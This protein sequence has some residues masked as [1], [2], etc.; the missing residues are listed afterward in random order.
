M[1]KIKLSG[2]IFL[3]VVVI[4]A[5]ET[6]DTQLHMEG[7]TGSSAAVVP[8]LVQEEKPTQ[9][10]RIKAGD[11][12][13]LT[14][15]SD[16]ELSNLEFIF[17]SSEFYN[18]FHNNRKDEDM[19]WIEYDINHDGTDEL[20]YRQKYNYYENAAMKRIVA[21]FAIQ[22]NEANLVLLDA[23]D[24]PRFYFLSSNG[25]L[26]YHNFQYGL[27]DSDSYT[28]Y[29]FD[30]EFRQ[31]VESTLYVCFIAKWAETEICETMQKDWEDESIR[32]IMLKNWKDGSK[33]VNEWIENNPDQA[34]AGIYFKEYTDTGEAVVLTEQEFM[35]AF[36]AMVG[37]SFLDMK[38]DWY[39]SYCAEW[40][41]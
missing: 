39:D 23:V 22:E 11:F 37:A 13:G 28:H 29:V 34:K 21:V 31:K 2:V 40:K 16:E 15:I 30:D 8:T 24:M 41:Y 17:D 33:S 6:K 35:N 3:L 12:S 27:G 26:I 9:K 19:E 7:A 4:S 38:P 18:Q 14:G 20:I 25:N 5:C 10:E 32:E 1:K 36:E